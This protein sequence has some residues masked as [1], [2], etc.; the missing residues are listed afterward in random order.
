MKDMV[1]IVK[2]HTWKSWNCIADNALT[3]K[4]FEKLIQLNEVIKTSFRNN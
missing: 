1:R 2:T 3:E 4:I